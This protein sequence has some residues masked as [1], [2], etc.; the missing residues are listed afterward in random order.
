MIFG[1]LY[2]INPRWNVSLKARLW[3]Q[4]LKMLSFPTFYP[5]KLGPLLKVL[6]FHVVRRGDARRV[7]TLVF[8]NINA[9]LVLFFVLFFLSICLLLDFRVCCSFWGPKKP[10]VFLFRYLSFSFSLHVRFTST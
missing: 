5:L 3:P 8:S 10:T 4:A 1:V 6:L 9:S 2:G 7:G